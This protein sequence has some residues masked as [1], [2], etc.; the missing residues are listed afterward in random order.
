MQSLADR[1]VY[2]LVSEAHSAGVVN[3]FYRVADRNEA[4]LDTAS[5]TSL[6]Y[7]KHLHEGSFRGKFRTSR[8]DQVSAR[9]WVRVTHRAG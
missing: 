2:Y 1:Q 4:W 6:G 3:T 8:S 9:H 7:S 5:L